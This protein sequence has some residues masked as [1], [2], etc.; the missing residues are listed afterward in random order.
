MRQY[1]QIP[2]GAEDTSAAFVGDLQPAM[3]MGERGP[4]KIWAMP[5][6][7]PLSTAA[8]FYLFD[9]ELLYRILF[10]E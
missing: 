2:G 8:A 10:E 7:P 3:G 6:S 5:P 9:I 4:H 1:V